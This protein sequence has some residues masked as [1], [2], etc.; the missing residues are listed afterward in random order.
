MPRTPT[1]RL[2]VILNDALAAT[3][4]VVAMATTAGETVYEGAAGTR[5]AAGRVPMTID[6]VFGLASMTKALV[7]AAALQEVDR[8]R[9]S[10]EGPIATVL[11]ELAA[12]QVLEGFAA[13]GTP[14]L[15]PARGAI[16]L[17]QL[18]S[19]SAGY[20]YD[21]WNAPIRRF[22]AD[23][24]HPRLPETPAQ[25]AA[26]PL[27]FD[28]GTRWNYGIATDVAGR[29]IEAASGRRLDHAMRD[30]LLGPLGMVDTDFTLNDERR[31]R[32]VTT[33]QRDADGFSD[34]G[35]F[36][37]RGIQWCMGG[38]G[39]SGTG[40][41]YLRF[42]RLILNGGVHEGQR[43]LS[44]ASMAR[45]AA[46]QLQPSVSVTPMITANPLRSNDVNLFPGQTKLWTA[47]FMLTPEAASTGRSAGSL[48]WAG[49]ANTYCWIDPAAGV[50]GVFMTQI[51]PFAD[52]AVLAAFA[53]FERAVYD[54]LA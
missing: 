34:L 43:L 14:Q 22:I 32:L 25:L 48:A 3:P 23:G 36:L 50:G 28:P 1:A 10:F 16:T 30:S 7:S 20:G 24:N 38:G 41:D 21:T 15:R 12:P 9:L 39:L 42:I 49:I 27:L 31:S 33:R 5:D 47:A 17:R 18:L 8:G 11:P 51:L 40:R 19:H 13:D 29:A 6:T 53:A 44:P 35:F 54:L 4:G 52:P 46:N 26:T 2:D 37:D 45:I